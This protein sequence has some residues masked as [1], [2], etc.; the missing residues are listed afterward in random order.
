MNKVDFARY[1]HDNTPYIMGNGVKE[2]INSL[3]EAS[4]KL[5]YWFAGNQ[6]KA[7]SDKCH[8][9]TSSSDKVSICMD[10]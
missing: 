2:V 8:S 6:M 10:N 5:F 1:A 7:N 3:K 9:L 4:D